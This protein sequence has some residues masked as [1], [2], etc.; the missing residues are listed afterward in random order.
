MKTFLKYFL[1]LFVI[2]LLSLLGQ[3]MEVP[4]IK[5][6]WLLAVVLAIIGATVV[7]LIKRYVN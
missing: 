3:E 2:Q 5:F 7:V 1:A 6:S 4:G